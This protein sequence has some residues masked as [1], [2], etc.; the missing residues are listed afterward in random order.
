[1]LVHGEGLQMLTLNNI[2]DILGIFAHYMNHILGSRLNGLNLSKNA[3]ILAM[4]EC[5]YSVFLFI[6]QVPLQMMKASPGDEES[7]SQYFMSLVRLGRTVDQQQVARDLYKRF[8]KTPYLYWA[9]MSTVQ[10]ATEV[11]MHV[12]LSSWF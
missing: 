10:Q 9:I 4:I 2:T 12:L 7:A 8:S 6:T 11:W 3:C 5:I 1:M